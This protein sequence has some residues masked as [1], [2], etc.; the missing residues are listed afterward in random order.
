[1]TIAACA[2]SPRPAPPEPPIPIAVEGRS[3][4]EIAAQDLK[5]R[6]DRE[7]R[8]READEA[9]KTFA[10]ML[11]EVET[12]CGARWLSEDKICAERASEL[13]ALADVYQAFYATEADPRA[14]EGRIDALP[15]LG[16]P[17]AS[18]EE[19]HEY[20]LYQCRERCSLARRIA[21]ADVIHDAV[22]SC[23]GKGGLAAC[24][25]LQRRV[26]PSAPQ[27]VVEMPDRCERECRE[28]RRAAEVEQ[29][30]ERE[31]PRTEAEER[32]CLRTCV[33]RCAGAHVAPDGTITHDPDAFCGT[34][35]MTCRA[36]CSRRR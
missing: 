23:A 29:K 24:R 10:I 12:T 5:D 11:G 33:G 32:A 28:R 34:C 2:A 22:E 36:R 7:Q 14:S 15:R 1:M 8:H 25:V 18:I 31:R 20:A 9:V 17:S 13:N 16:G 21:I 4:P 35:E 26:P 6:Q 30:I 19:V 3:R 27:S